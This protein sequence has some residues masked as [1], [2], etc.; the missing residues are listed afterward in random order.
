M[1]N[2]YNYSTLSC[3]SKQYPLFNVLQCRYM[4]TDFDNIWQRVYWDNTQ[5]KRPHLRDVAALPWEKLIIS[6]K[7]FGRFSPVV[8][9]W[10]WK[11]PFFWCWDEDTDL[12]MGPNC[13]WLKWPQL[14]A[15]QAVKH[16]V[17][18]ATTLLM[19]YRGGSCQMVCKTTFS[20]PSLLF[21]ALAEVYGTFPAWRPDV[22]VQ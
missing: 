6:F 4:L 17:K 9:G 12:E 10:F 8:C 5:H 7:H 2:Y 20:S 18:F 14:A 22:I 11:K 16:L 21:G 19:C 1:S 3:E 15:M 13:R